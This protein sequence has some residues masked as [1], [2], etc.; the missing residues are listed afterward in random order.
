MSVNADSGYVNYMMI[1]AFWLCL[2]WLI[3]TIAESI[4]Y[5]EVHLF[6]STIAVLPTS[7]FYPGIPAA[8]QIQFPCWIC[9]RSKPTYVC[10]CINYRHKLATELCRFIC[11][12]NNTY[13]CNMKFKFKTLALTGTSRQSYC[14]SYPH[15]TADQSNWQIEQYVYESRVRGKYTTQ[16]HI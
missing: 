13:L 16:H 5:P 3:D 4:W 10:V 8:R 15:F 11:H 12:N 7:V 9:S 1:S 6:L 14:V 2:C